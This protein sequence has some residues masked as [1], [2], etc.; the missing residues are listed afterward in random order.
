MKIS[1]NIWPWVIC[2]SLVIVG[3]GSDAMGADVSSSSGGQQDYGATKTMVID[4]LHSEEGKSALQD[5][6]KDP[7]FKQQLVVSDTDITKAITAS[8]ESKKTQSFLADQAKDPK[9]AAALAK[10]VQPDLIATSKQLMKDPDYQKDMLTLLQSPE[11][12][13]NLQT[14]MQGPEFRTD[15][16]KIMTQALD[17]PAFRMKF[18][19]AL[20]SAV[21][22]A[23]KSSGGGSNSSSSGGSSGSSS[24]S[25]SS[26]SGGSES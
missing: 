15:V 14:L 22:D 9:F 26:S 16:Q 10:A 11:F 3:C 18:Q 5:V 20:K 6:M 12:T 25:S 2:S 21:N 7:A 1:K 13:K 17:T 19:D 8:I 23:M 24:G 4:I